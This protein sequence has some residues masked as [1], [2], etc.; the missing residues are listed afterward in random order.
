MSTQAFKTAI[1]LLTCA[2]ISAAAL[3][4]NGQQQV[5]QIGPGR[6]KEILKMQTVPQVILPPEPTDPNPKPYPVEPVYPWVGY[7]PYHY[8][9][10]YGYYNR[11]NN[12]YTQQVVVIPQTV[13]A[14]QPVVPPRELTELDYAMDAM[15]SGKTSIAIDKFLEHLKTNTD[16]FVAMRL[17][18]MMYLEEKQPSEAASRIAFAYKRMPELARRPI[19]AAELRLDSGRLREM[20]VRA[21]KYANK[22]KTGSGWLLVTVLMQAE[23]RTEFALTNLAKAEAA[24]LDP[25]TVYNLRSALAP[26]E[27]EQIPVA[28]PLKQADD[29]TGVTNEKTPAEPAAPKQDSPKNP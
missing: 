4:A 10:D 2:V 15:Q 20:V 14:P 12:G 28:S 22:M 17:I 3:P 26:M 9:R 11:Y 23:G 7:Y 27:V 21:S 1:A 24:G 16:D 19:D 6:G 5:N 29:A 18:G 25:E 13:A 8:G